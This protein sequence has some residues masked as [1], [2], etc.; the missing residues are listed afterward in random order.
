MAQLLS[1]Q[2]TVN[3]EH[4]NSASNIAKL[5][6]F[7]EL[8]QSK[9]VIPNIEDITITNDGTSISLDC[10]ISFLDKIQPTIDF[11]IKGTPATE[12]SEWDVVY[13]V[14]HTQESPQFME[15][16]LQPRFRQTAYLVGKMLKD[17]SIVIGHGRS[18]TGEEVVTLKSSSPS[19][20]VALPLL[21]E[22]GPTLAMGYRIWNVNDYKTCK[23]LN[24]GMPFG[25]PVF[26]TETA[27]VVEYGFVDSAN[28][29]CKLDQV[30]ASHIG[31][32]NPFYY[33]VRDIPLSYLKS[34]G[35]L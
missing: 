20:A 2:L 7:K 18:S 14:K 28:N 23:A 17:G 15:S 12:V 22:H 24:I 9:L 26:R 33:A 10:D 27:H 11:L 13:E 4:P 21:L 6:E 31:R 34:I 30:N 8:M 25:T 35:E 19:F 16:F 29:L 5:N 3:K 1:L 32:G